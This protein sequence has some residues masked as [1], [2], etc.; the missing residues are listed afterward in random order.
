M[1]Y[2]DC[3]EIREIVLNEV[4]KEVETLSFTP[5]LHIITVGYDAASEVYVNNKIK[6]AESVGI[7]VVHHTFGE[8]V[9]Q[10]EMER[11]MIDI[12]MKN[13]GAIM[14][15]LPIP[16]H[17][18]ANK[19]ISYIPQFK[20]VD[21]LTSINMG[22]LTHNY[23]EAIIPAT[24]QACYEIIKDTI[25]D[26]L[27]GYRVTIVNRSTLIGLPLQA[28]LTNHNATVTLCHSKTN[29]T[30]LRDSM[31]N[32]DIIITGIGIP[33][34]FN[35]GD[36]SAYDQLIIDCGISRNSKGLMVGDW[37]ENDLVLNDDHDKYYITP[38]G[39]KR[40]GVGSI[41]TACLMK[42]VL[43]CCKLQQ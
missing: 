11:N 17:L 20:D 36:T 34:Y 13:K 23:Y 43:K 30:Y 40:A 18:N 42:S 12:C 41:T 39:K 31:L 1:Q 4:K 6:T 33:N 9:Q 37:N 28:L 8:D 14:L 2:I 35:Y 16:R 38:V 26:D 21:G 22:M 25:S 29:K 19:L 10:E 24:A 7:K 5:E 15:Q 32:S 3:K 27:S